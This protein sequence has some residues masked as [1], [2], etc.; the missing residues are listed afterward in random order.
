M[1][2]TSRSET[3]APWQERNFSRLLL[4][5]AIAGLIP[6]LILGYSQFITL[7]GWWHLFVATQDRWLMVAAEWKWIAHPPLFYPLLRL[8]A[9][10]SQSPLALRSIGIICGALSTVVI[11]QVGAKIYRHKPSAL[12][13]AAAWT[14]AWSIIDL[15]CDVR[16]YSLALLFI[17]LAFNAWLDWNT[18]PRG[19]L[20]RRAIL[21][22]G[23]WSSLAILS[24][25]Y[26]ILFLA[27]CFAI[28]V[29]RF[30]MRPAFRETLQASV[31][32]HWQ[33]WLFT[34]VSPVT[35]FGIFAF[36]QLS[37]KAS[38][39][40]Y[41][42]PFLWNNPAVG[43]DDFLLSNLQSELGL[44]APFQLDSA[45]AIALLILLPA[46]LWFGC[47]RAKDA[48]L[49]LIAIFLQIALLSLFAIYPFGGEFR[50]Q[51]ILAPFAFITGFL[52]LDRLADHLP[53]PRI[54]NAMFTSAGLLL[55]ATF[56]FGWTVYPW[57]STPLDYAEYS[58]L[59]A[60]FPHPA[61][62]YVDRASAMYYFGENHRAK[63]ILQD[64]FLAREQRITA[65]KVEDGQNPPTRFL[66]NKNQP[67]LELTDPETYQVL[68]ATLIH[69]GLPSAVIYCVGRSWS[70][71]GAR[72]LESKLL[73]LAPANGLDLGR[74]QIGKNYVIAEF[75]LRN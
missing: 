74:Y 49:L 44:F 14:F 16:A 17:L 26:T 36:F 69:E 1:P 62:L 39:Q 12:L 37:V 50:H 68:T 66:Q 11:G 65:Y 51:S 45:I 42:Q 22:F 59:Q 27:A 48:P 43:L 9:R 63:W 10:L 58:H 21:R 28:L 47:R 15:N 19:T 6:R 2:P 18:A 75:R 13:L 57:S 38:N 53:Q 29:L 3:T 5:I 64:R 32:E 31:R 52:L 41:L 35:L 54:R 55:T 56:T 46:L 8:A 4:A 67:H 20:A 7:D 72:T 33:A 60:L 70:S 30:L 23:L 34:T 71:D 73:S 61:S 40:R 25:Y 24:E